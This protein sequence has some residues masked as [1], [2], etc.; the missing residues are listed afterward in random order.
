MGKS[1]DSEIAL[2]TCAIL[3]SVFTIGQTIYIFVFFGSRWRYGKGN[4][5]TLNPYPSTKYNHN[6]VYDYLNIIYL[7]CMWNDKDY[8]DDNTVYNDNA[9]FLECGSLHM[10]TA[11]Y[12]LL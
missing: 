5:E 11:S 8:A 9:V 3:G 7:H 6:P 4:F 10:Y 1:I 2:S 12:I